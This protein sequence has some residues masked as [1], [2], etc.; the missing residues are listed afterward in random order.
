MKRN[1]FNTLIRDEMKNRFEG[2]VKEEINS[3]RK[4]QEEIFK[5]FEL[6]NQNLKLMKSEIES[7]RLDNETRCQNVSELYILERKNLEESFDEQRRVIRTVV[8]EIR[9]L[10]NEFKVSR[11]KYATVEMIESHIGD[12]LGL[13]SISKIESHREK[14]EL[15]NILDQNVKELI[16]NDTE[17]LC[18]CRGSSDELSKKIEKV[19][20]VIE[21]FRVSIEGFSREITVIKKGEFILEKKIENLYTQLDRVKKNVGGIY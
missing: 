10:V 16:K 11:E 15:L 6:I 21:D 9:D 4:E 2:A 3:Y 7:L 19:N 1:N 18:L 5:N 13:M 14:E 17:S 8:N 12:V 20:Q